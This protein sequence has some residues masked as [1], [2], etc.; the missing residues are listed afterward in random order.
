MKKQQQQK[1]EWLQMGHGKYEEIPDEKSFF[2]VS[3]KSKN[4][5]CHFYREST[6]RCKIVDKH[7]AIL[8]PKHL[9]ARFIKLNVEK[10]KFLVDRLKIVVLPTIC[11]IKESKS[12]DY[13]VGFDDLGSTDEFSTEMLEWRIA[14][15]DIITYSGDLL[16]PPDGSAGQGKPKLSYAGGSDGRKKTIRGGRDDDD[17][18]DD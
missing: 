5:I 4:V 6:F 8:A 15:A 13:I 2:D 10:C 7:L 12:M 16:T 3:K 1:V 18:D 17:S 11:L 9:E 14:R